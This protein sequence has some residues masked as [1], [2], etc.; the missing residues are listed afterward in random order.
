MKALFSLAAG[1]DVSSQVTRTDTLNFY[2]NVADIYKGPACLNPTVIMQP[3][4]SLLVNNNLKFREFLVEQSFN[5]GTVEI[6][7]IQK[8]GLTH[9]VKFEVI[10]SVDATPSWKTKCW[11]INPTGTLLTAN[12]DRTHEI[13]VT[14]GPSDPSQKMLVGATASQVAASQLATAINS[15]IN[16]AIVP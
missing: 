13:S 2:Y 16:S 7:S 4:G 12:R 14:F 9:D 11:S 6:T 3:T 8:N 5:V 10:S 1:F 15:R